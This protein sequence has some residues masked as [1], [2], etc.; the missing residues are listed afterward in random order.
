MVALRDRFNV[1]LGCD[2]VLFHRQGVK[3]VGNAEPGDVPGSGDQLLA[4]Q[5]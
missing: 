3:S 2:N 5:K 1:N 4:E